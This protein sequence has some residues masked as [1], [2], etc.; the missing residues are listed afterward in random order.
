[1]NLVYGWENIIKRAWSVRLVIIASLLS[2][3][4][5]II[6]MFSDYFPRGLFAVISFVV[7]V[8]ALV[9]RITAQPDLHR[10]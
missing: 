4:E 2:G 8:G 6:P 9:A 5:V 1:M 7:T 10:P 3:L